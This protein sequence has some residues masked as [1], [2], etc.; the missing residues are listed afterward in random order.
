MRLEPR[1][2]RDN[3]VEDGGRRRPLDVTLGAMRILVDVTV[4]HPCAQSRVAVGSRAR[5]AVADQA[6]KAKTT[7]HAA[8]TLAARPRAT[9]VPFVLET[10]GGIGKQACGFIKEVLKLAGDLAYVWA[11]KELVY[12]LPQAIAIALQRGNA[13]A[14]ADCLCNAEE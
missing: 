3:P 5:L 7:H 2:P 4:R 10:F 9:F 8:T 13:K 6:E 14:V 11:P 1:P 12:G